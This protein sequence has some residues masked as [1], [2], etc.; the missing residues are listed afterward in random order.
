MLRS[1]SCN[2][3]ASYIVIKGAID[4]LDTAANEN[5]KAE[6]NCA[7]QNNAPFKSCISKINSTLI[8][9]AEDLGIVMSMYNLLEYSQNC[10]MTAGGLRNYYSDEIDNINDNVSDGKWFK[11]KTKIVQKTP[12]PLG[13]ENAYRS[14]VPTLN[15]EVT[16]PIKYVRNLWR[17]IDLPLINCEVEFDLSR[18]ED[19]VLIEH[20]DDITGV[21]F[22]IANFM[23]I[24]I[25][26]VY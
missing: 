2:Y 22:M 3:S 8:D 4:L 6:Q 5:D 20:H 15:V 12:A 25:P 1:D 19:C 18:T 7:L 11:C 21:N 17:F 14:A 23:K 13:K 26:L 9:N 16:I 24:Y 10:S